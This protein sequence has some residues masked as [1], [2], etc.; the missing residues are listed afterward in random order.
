MLH[1]MCQEPTKHEFNTLYDDMIKMNNMIKEWLK[2]G[3]KEN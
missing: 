3:P 2:V 1:K